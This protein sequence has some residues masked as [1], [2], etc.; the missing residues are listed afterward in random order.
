M[1]LRD[2]IS[3]PLDWIINA[4]VDELQEWPTTNINEF[5]MEEASATSMS[6]VMARIVER[7]NKARR[8]T[9]AV[10]VG[11]SK[12]TPSLFDQFPLACSEHL[13]DE[14]AQ[15][16]RKVV[17]FKNNL[18]P[19]RGGRRIIEPDAAQSYFSPC[20]PGQLC[21]R[22]SLRPEDM[23][24]DMF[25]LTPY[26]WFKN[27]YR[28]RGTPKTAVGEHHFWPYKPTPPPEDR[29]IDIVV[30]RFGWTNGGLGRLKEKLERYKGDCDVERAVAGCRPLM[31]RWRELAASWRAMKTTGKVD[32]APYDCRED[33][34]AAAMAAAMAAEAAADEGGDEDE[35]PAPPAAA[36]NTAYMGLAWEE[37]ESRLKV[38]SKV[39]HKV[40]GDSQARLKSLTEGGA[41]GENVK[42]RWD[43]EIKREFGDDSV[44]NAP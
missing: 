10:P 11:I 34:G 9:Q 13:L 15:P 3:E 27:R 7:T 25:N 39:R 21:P 40:K 2:Y 42:T 30:H 1:L 33:S 16:K 20:T 17:A 32:T 6:Y 24:M 5:L 31:P 26:A 14:Y 41:K 23:R 29:G 19:A 44:Q 36:I 28:Y 38:E 8:I 18:R 35:V 37:F 43:D 22:A 12:H 4:E